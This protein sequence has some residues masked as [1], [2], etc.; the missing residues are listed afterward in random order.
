MRRALVALFLLSS[1]ESSAQ[2][3]DVEIFPLGATCQFVNN[4]GKPRGFSCAGTAFIFD[5]QAK[6]GFNCLFGV[7]AKYRQTSNGKVGIWVVDTPPTAHT[8][9]YCLKQPNFYF[10]PK[11]V[12]MQLDAPP[13]Q[14]YLGTYVISYNPAS[15]TIKVCIDPSNVVDG[16]GQTACVDMDMFGDLSE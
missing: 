8:S 10:D 15:K 14:R 3:A 7:G 6:L 9:G 16:L 13:V 4:P 11:E 12:L 5:R 1:F 2:A